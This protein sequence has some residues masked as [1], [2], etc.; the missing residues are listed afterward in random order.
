MRLADAVLGKA[1]D[2]WQVGERWCLFKGPMAYSLSQAS[3]GAGAVRPGDL[4]SPADHHKHADLPVR[5][6]RGRRVHPRLTHRAAWLG[7]DGDLPVIEGTLI[8]LRVDHLPGDRDPKTVWL[9]C[10]RTGAALSEVDW[11]WQA[12]P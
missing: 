6:G 4:A 1:H 2:E 12:P 10:S 9:W 7:H 8:R 11:L 3:R 5:D